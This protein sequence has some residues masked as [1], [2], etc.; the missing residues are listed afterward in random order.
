M[1]PP[2]LRPATPTKRPRK[3]API[4]PIPAWATPHLA[5]ALSAGKRMAVLTRASRGADK[6]ILADGSEYSLE[7]G[8]MPLTR[9]QLRTILEAPTAQEAAAIT[10]TIMEDNRLRRRDYTSPELLAAATRH[11]RMT[12]I[13]TWNKRGTQ[14][15]LEWASYTLH[16][17]QGTLSSG[18]P[19]PT[20]SHPYPRPD[21]V[22]SIKGMPIWKA[23][24]RS[25]SGSRFVPKG[26]AI[27]NEILDLVQG[28]MRIRL[29]MWRI[30]DTLKKVE[31]LILA[32]G[33]KSISANNMLITIYPSNIPGPS[34]FAKDG[35]HYTVPVPYLRLNRSAGGLWVYNSCGLTSIG[36]GFI[37]KDWVIEGNSSLSAVLAA[38]AMKEVGINLAINP[39][40]E[41][42]DAVALLEAS[43][44]EERQKAIPATSPHAAVLLSPP[45]QE[46]NNI[47]IMGDD[48]VLGRVLASIWELSRLHPRIKDAILDTVLDTT[49]P[50]I[51]F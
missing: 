1:R 42:R 5:G 8:E 23:A 15:F 47:E 43:I 40:M 49:M 50:I 35:K 18:P 32:A 44:K 11:I 38:Y 7:G 3:G 21:E 39:I 36:P 17:P 16:A 46:P 48:I 20:P 28:G 14:G 34:Y 10:R 6:A 26:Q 31:G 13:R 24:M 9:K 19:V 30:A 27:L 22:I 4:L 12:G 37:R 25:R 45:I 33:V 51:N 2:K 41:L 29:S